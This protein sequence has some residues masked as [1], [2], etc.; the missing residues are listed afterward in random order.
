MPQK[1]CDI[2]S[3][4]NEIFTAEKRNEENYVPMK[5]SLRFLS[6]Q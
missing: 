6:T 4:I 2:V 3:R 5:E 1:T